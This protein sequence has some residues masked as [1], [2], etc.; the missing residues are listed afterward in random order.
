MTIR[1]DLVHELAGLN[2]YVNWDEE[3]GAIDGPL[4]AELALM[5]R[6]AATARRVTSHPYPTEYEIGPEPLR[7]PRDLALVISQVWAVPEQLRAALP[8]VP[9]D[10]DDDQPADVE[11]VY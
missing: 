4:A 2:G 11:V 10:D 3:T 6:E 9:S 8:A 1:L 7:S 5:A